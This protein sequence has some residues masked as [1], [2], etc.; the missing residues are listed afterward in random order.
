MALPGGERTLQDIFFATAGWCVA[1]GFLS[2]PCHGSPCQPLKVVEATW[3]CTQFF[4]GHNSPELP[5]PSVE[6]SLKQQNQ[7][8]L[9]LRR[10]W[11]LIYEICLCQDTEIPIP[12][13]QKPGRTGHAEGRMK[14]ITFHLAWYL[15]I[16]CSGDSEGY[17]GYPEKGRNR[18][19]GIWDS[20]WA[21]IFKQHEPRS[22]RWIV[23]SEGHNMFFS[24]FFSKT[25]V[26]S[27]LDFPLQ[28][29]A[30]T[31]FSH[32]LNLPPGRCCASWSFSICIYFT[33]RLLS[34]G[35][36]DTLRA[37]G[38]GSERLG[39]G[40]VARWTCLQLLWSDWLRL[41]RCPRSYPQVL[42]NHYHRMPGRLGRNEKNMDLNAIDASEIRQYNQ[43]IW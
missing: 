13:M 40:H 32:P 35:T 1:P 37:A 22:S 33:L 23:P 29:M 19:K 18:G 10:V 2:T 15:A 42:W 34:H 14:Q 20:H 27:Y 31:I 3:V 4:I 11:F 39:H 24:C 7:E 16:E 25:S 38:A 12:P 43:L 30:M 28:T 9:P 17:T 8:I 21:K 36:L 26:V 41:A 6:K 5:W